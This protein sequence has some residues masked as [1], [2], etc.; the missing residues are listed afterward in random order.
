MQQQPGILQ[1]AE[2]DSPSI[3]RRRFTEQR[4]ACPAARA[5][6]SCSCQLMQWP[7]AEDFEVA[8]R[9][10]AAV[11]RGACVLDVSAANCTDFEYGRYELVGRDLRE[12]AEHWQPPDPAHS[13]EPQQLRLLHPLD[14]AHAACDLNGQNGIGRGA[15]VQAERQ[16][17][18]QQHG[19]RRQEQR[20]VQG[21][22]VR[23]AHRLLEQVG[24]S[25]AALCIA[26]GVPSA[27]ELRVELVNYKKVMLHLFNES[28]V[29]EK[30]L[31]QMSALLHVPL[32][33][34]AATAESQARYSALSAMVMDCKGSRTVLQ[35][36]RVF[37]KTICTLNRHPAARAPA[38]L[39]VRSA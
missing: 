25:V 9:T 16:Q 4:T 37:V 27:F 23:G 28:T 30:D 31:R 26:H 11:H 13:G 32:E 39:L 19:E 10:A 7:S 38:R 21:L 8:V 20:P 15:A 35:D 2:A 24:R 34:G 22:N 36:A 6:C 33:P 18:Q 5:S 29:V 17:Q 12:V 14:P 1:P 3:G